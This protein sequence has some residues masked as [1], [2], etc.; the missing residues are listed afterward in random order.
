[1]IYDLHAHSN[2]S[3]GVLAPRELVQ[4]AQIAGVGALALTDHDTTAGLAEAA[5]AAAAVGIELVA[6]VEISATAAGRTVHVLGLGID[7]SAPALAAL[8]AAQSAARF[9]RASGINTALMRAGLRDCWEVALACAQGGTLGRP[10]FARALVATGQVPDEKLAFKRYLGAGCVGDISCDWVPLAAAVAAIGAAGGIACLAHPCKYKLTRTRLL[11]LLE[12]FC[13]AGGGGLEVR[14]GQQAEPET[15][16][17][18]IIARK[19]GLAASCG[20]DFH[21]PA[22]PW[23]ALGRAWPLPVEATPVWSRHALGAGPN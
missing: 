16:D 23:Q 6:G 18:C 5:V 9:E 20:S 15:R 12:Q 21:D 10:H 2:A 11:A 14:S 17:L 19:F 22:Q 8:L 1:M 13:D 4:A 7:P 3:D